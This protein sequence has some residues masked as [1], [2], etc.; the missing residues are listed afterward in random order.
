VL[1]IQQSKNITPPK[2]LTIWGRS[3]FI[4]V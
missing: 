3:G 4:R 1:Q 2:E